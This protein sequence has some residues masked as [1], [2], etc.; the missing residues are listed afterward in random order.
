M[1][2]DKNYSKY[3]A[4]FKKEAKQLAKLGMNPHPHIVRV[5]DFF[6][7]DNLPC[8]VMDYVPGD[9]LYDLVQMNGSLSEEQALEYVR[10]IGS[11]LTACHKRGIIHRDV[12]PNNIL[13]HAENGKAILIDF[14][15]SG[16]TQTSRSNR[17]G[18]QAFAPWEQLISFGEQSSKTPQVDIYTLAAS[19]YYLVTGDTPIPSLARKFNNDELI[20]PKQY[21]SQISDRTNQGILKGMKIEIGDRPQTVKAWLEMLKSPQP[22]PKPE[23]VIQPRYIN[24]PTQPVPQRNNQPKQKITVAKQSVESRNQDKKIVEKT[25]IDTVIEKRSNPISQPITRRKWLKWVGFSGLGFFGASIFSLLLLNRKIK[26]T[27]KS[28]ETIPSSSEP[29][30]LKPQEPEKIEFTE[31]KISDTEYSFDVI[32]VND[33]G[34]EINR[35]KGKA[36]YFTED[37]GSG[38]TLDMVEIPGGT[39]MMG[40]ER[41]E[42]ERLNKKYGNKYLTDLFNDESPQHEV[43]VPSFYM[44][45]FEVTQ[46]QWRQVATMPKV[47]KELKPEPSRFKGDNLPVD[48]IAWHDAVEFCKR[49]SKAT[50]KEYRLPSEAEWEYA[51]RAGT[52][53]PFHFGETITTELANY[54]GYDTFLNDEI[55]KE[56]F[57]ANEPKALGGNEPT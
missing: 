53:T 32:T 17:S 39:F 43:K 3:L 54:R 48:W 35:E 9:S 11:A 57:Y 24:P 15:I 20:E 19:F 33:R 22:K 36:S 34:E 41:E 18:N 55:N 31:T 23:P 8:I 7:E 45:K 1:Q 14:G 28:E 30:A 51:C 47:D 44:A 12:H 21:N 13:L 10:Q 16:S 2:R 46:A 29:E 25:Q 40:T 26:D 6:E 5:L 50:D 56:I 37:L 27:D 38:V 4:N 42:I 49:L 52:T